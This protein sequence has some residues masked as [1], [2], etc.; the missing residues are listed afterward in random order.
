[1]SISRIRENMERPGCQ[2]IV[3]I[4]LLGMA[5]GFL[6]GGSQ[7]RGLLGAGQGNNGRGDQD[8]GEEI[9]TV[10]DYKI[11][12]GPIQKQVNGS[13]S[14]GGGG[15]NP[16][17]SSASD[18]ATAY[19]RALDTQ[20]TQ[21][22]LLEEAKQNGFSL[23]D[24]AI[25]EAAG[26]QSDQQMEE[27]KMMAPMQDKTLPQNMTDQQFSDY[28]KKKTGKTPE[29]Q[30]A[31]QVDQ[32][33]KLLSDPQI[34]DA[35]LR[36]FA[37]DIVMNGFS[38]SIPV[39]DDDLKHSRDQ[40][41]SKRI[42]FLPSKHKGEDME[43]LANQVAADLK[44][45]KI[46]FEQ[47]MDKYSDDSVAK[48]KKAEDNTNEVD[49]MTW[50]TNPDYAKL[51]DLKQG[52]VSDV[53]DIKP[54]GYA[55]YRLDNIISPP[56]PNFDKTKD[57]MKKSYLQ[58]LEAEKLQ[59]GLKQLRSSGVIKWD[60]PD[61]GLLEDW[62]QATTGQDSGFSSKPKAEQLKIDQ[63]FVDK[64]LASKQ[65]DPPA[66]LTAAGAFDP[67]WTGASDA[68][69]KTLSD[70][71]EKILTGFVGQFPCFSARMELVKLAVAKG[72]KEKDVVA[73][74]LLAAVQINQQGVS[75]PSGQANFSDI[76]RD[77]DLYYQKGLLTKDEVA[78]IQ[79]KLDSF[80]DEKL[81]Y[82]A[83]N[84]QEQK[85]EAIEKAK[86]EAE[87]A[88]EE[89]SK[90][91]PAPPAAPPSSFG[92][93]VRAL[94]PGPGGA[95]APPKISINPTPPPVI[96]PGGAPPAKTPPAGA[97]PTVKINPPPVGGK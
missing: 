32:Y 51:K 36:G 91:K 45:K 53:V 63:S 52:E 80:R 30:K 95:G 38:K 15:L 9:A 57:S 74:N 83:Q 22:L 69:K 25:L 16:L 56:I 26:S 96:H 23:D 59:D 94:P 34:H 55:I 84:L 78:Q 90:P 77:T 85:Q 46:T 11:Y 19:A 87:K 29:Q 89:A 21:C 73:Q 49:T 68:E 79:D 81:R 14:Q 86:E 67:I 64:A 2:W 50:K 18:Y 8:Q 42:A 82:D 20:V 27:Q 7:C 70:E 40:Y 65:Q 62:N 3:T 60:V 75:D 28:W 61:W 93:G 43:K 1:M 24:D 4:I 72:T 66:F 48:G 13:P 41:V 71:Y 47:A 5:G 6:F 92:K 44:A 35:M 76:A 54:E 37:N 97:K 88:K 39:T 17:T 10:G 12:L 31:E 33:K 58:T